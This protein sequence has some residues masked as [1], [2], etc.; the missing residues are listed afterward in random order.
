MGPTGITSVKFV[1]KKY[2]HFSQWPI[3]RPVRKKRFI[4]QPPLAPDGHQSTFV[5]CFWYI[6]PGY[7]GDCIIKQLDPFKNC[8]EG[9]TGKA[10]VLK[11]S[12]TLCG[13][14]HSVT[15]LG[16]LTWGYSVGYGVE[17]GKYLWLW[18][19]HGLQKE[20]NKYKSHVLLSPHSLCVTFWGSDQSHFWVSPKL[21]PPKLWQAQGSQ[22]GHQALQNASLQARVWEG[23][24][25]S[26]WGWEIF[27]SRATTNLQ[28]LDW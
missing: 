1:A 25:G 2:T 18:H 9:V 19:K 27:N 4:S 20:L 24:P 8:N 28:K 15:F 10:T 22:R 6:C 23:A 7:P 17:F 14:W 5:S 16:R 3:C 21:L 26:R 12:V 13:L 11:S